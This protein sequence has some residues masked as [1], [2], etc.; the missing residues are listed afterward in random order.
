M[1]LGLPDHLVQPTLSHALAR[2][3]HWF[4]LVCLAGALLSVAILSLT[5]VAPRLW[6][7]VLVLLAMA[8][9]LAAL[10]QRR[11]VL[12]SVAYLVLGTCCVYLYTVTVLGVPEVFPASN[13]FL[14][15]LPKMALVMVGGAGSG[16]FTGV[17]W[18]STGFV[19]A[20][21][22]T[23]FAVTHTRVRYEADVFTICTY[24]AL[25]GV[26]IFVGLG[27]RVGGGA[28]QTIHRAVQDGANRQ[29]RDALD[30]RAIALL[31]DTTVSQLVALSLAEPGE[32]SP[33]LRE[34]IRHALHTLHDTNWLADADAREAGGDDWLASAVYTAIE[35]Y[36]DRGLVVEVTGDRSA[37]TRL[38]AASDRELGL[39]VQ[40]CLVNVI[41]HAGIASAEVNFESDAE[42]VSVM[43]TDA[44]RGFTVSDS[45]S[46]RLGLRQSVRRRID[47]LGGSVAIWSR[48]GAGTNVRLTVPAGAAS[49]ATAPHPA[50]ST[51][52]SAE[53]SGIASTNPSAGSADERVAP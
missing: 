26:M 6:I 50:A 39:A 15:A 49:A 35:R 8:G 13:M 45:G 10:T 24:L 30:A 5:P 11:T 34:S 21:A 32:L 43:V 28:Q 22:T 4:G 27:R 40:H 1:T 46:D 14:I 44:G 25:V 20:E 31:N 41:L 52:P 2:A 19:L 12:L 48:P 47:Q 38:D 23:F 29:L 7:T 53:P 37:L 33:S 18:S 9:L 17:L 42:S 36:R 16:A 51:S 3:A